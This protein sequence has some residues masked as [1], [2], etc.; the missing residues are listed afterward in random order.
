MKSTSA[1][2]EDNP[3]TGAASTNVDL[4]IEVSTTAIVVN[5]IYYST[6]A[7][8]VHAFEIGTANKQ[9]KEIDLSGT[10]TITEADLESFFIYGCSTTKC[11]RTYGYITNGS[12]YYAVKNGS[13]NAK[14]TTLA[15]SCS[16]VGSLYTSNTLCIDTT[17]ANAKAFINDSTISNYVMTV[18]QGNIFTGASSSTNGILIRGTKNAYVLNNFEV[19]NNQKYIV[20]DDSGAY[21]LYSYSSTGSI[22]TKVTTASLAA[23]DLITSTDA[24]FYNIVDLDNTST[25]YPNKA[26][27]A[28]MALFE[29][30][31][32]GICKNTYGYIKSG[33]R[34]FAIPKPSGENDI[35]TPAACGTSKM[36]GLL[37]GG[38]LCLSN[39][40]TTGGTMAD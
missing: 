3:F 26:S 24:T 6:L 14:I 11:V 36:G 17:N 37:T 30:A 10:P 39:D 35:V 34:F 15:T 25:K 13:A 31:S 32:T 40:D 12:T 7:A 16:T 4:V 28:K 8:G 38:K 19:E 1:I 2:V 22:M 29:C 23:Y 33:E 5:P 27:L 20:K 21:T 18:A 9:I